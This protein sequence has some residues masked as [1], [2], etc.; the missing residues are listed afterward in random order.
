MAD[1][2][3]RIP[4]R[5]GDG[6]VPSATGRKARRDPSI[7]YEHLINLL[8][9]CVFETDRH[10]RLIRISDRCPRHLGYHPAEL[11][12]CFLDD[13]IRPVTPRPNTGTE[14]RRQPFRNILHAYVSREGAVGLV[15]VSA[16]PFYDPDAGGFEGMMGWL[17]ETSDSPIVT[18]TLKKLLLRLDGEFALVLIS[19]PNGRILYAN[20]RFR[21]MSGHGESELRGIKRDG[22]VSRD[23]D[24]ADPRAAAVAAL[25]RFGSWFGAAMY[26]TRDARPFS[27]VEV[28]FRIDLPR[29]ETA[30]DLWLAYDDMAQR[31]I[32]SIPVPVIDGRDDQIIGHATRVLHTVTLLATSLPGFPV[33]DPDAWRRAAP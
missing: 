22:L 6:P 31:M 33:L 17:R 21:E 29:M 12:G 25:E 3:D 14:Q 23:D 20:P 15:N 32:Q 27:V 19:D 16:A 18:Q 2:R 10:F 13:V 28:A 30:L 26:R 5:A 1:R 11:I 24:D 8:D 7:R 4:E 9:D